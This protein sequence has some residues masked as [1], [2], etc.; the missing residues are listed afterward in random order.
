MEAEKRDPGNE[1]AS[2]NVSY[3]NCLVTCN[4]QK[5]ETL[6]FSFGYGLHV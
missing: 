5:S 2:A 4:L 1:V 3:A 6:T